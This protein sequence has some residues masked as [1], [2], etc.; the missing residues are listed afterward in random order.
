VIHRPRKKL[1]GPK[2]D[3]KG[4]KVLLDE[5]T[6]ADLRSWQK[7][8]DDYDK[9][10]VQLF[11]HLEGLRRLHHDEILEALQASK[12]ASLKM[13]NW[14]RII[15]YKYSLDPLSAVG[16][17]VSGGRFNIG[18]NLNPAQF[19]EYA[20]LYV[21]E[22][23][24]TAYAEKFAVALSEDGAG[25]SGH[26]FALRGPTSYTHVNISGE[27]NNLFN[28]GR[29]ANFT[30]FIEVIKRFK[31]TDELKALARKIGKSP[32]LLVADRKMLKSTLLANDW[33]GWPTQFEI[34]A[35]SQV[36]GRLIRDAGYEG[37]MYPSTKGNGKCTALFPENF[38]GSD[39][40]L[41]LADIPP[42]GA[43]CIRLDSETWQDLIG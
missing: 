19:P 17:L 12:P 31:L 23:H 34:P 21:A 28:V 37:I 40:Y 14:A 33:S 27:L 3:D 9:Y 30:E 25:L 13:N 2:G 35:N 26:E 1:K 16:S 4:T 7:L 41:E 29:A 10:H 11:Y 8:A 15:G 20:A 32:P 24:K 38:A 39:S 36:M 43:K 18:R 6:V 22:N 5:F 42:D